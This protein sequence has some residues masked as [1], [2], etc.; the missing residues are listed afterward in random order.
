MSSK[1]LCPVGVLPAKRVAAW[2]IGEPVAEETRTNQ[3]Y[4]VRE[5]Q[6]LHYPPPHLF[7]FVLEAVIGLKEKE[8]AK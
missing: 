8:A 4:S 6:L 3:L 1:A 5:H 2:V 7:S